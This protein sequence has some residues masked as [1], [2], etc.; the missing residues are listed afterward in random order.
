MATTIQ[1]YAKSKKVRIHQA[2]AVIKAVLGE[3]PDNL[4]DEDI[5]R[6]ELANQAPSLPPSQD[7]KALPQSEPKPENTVTVSEQPE[8]PQPQPEEPQPQSQPVDQM[9]TAIQT[10]Q[11]Q[12]TSQPALSGS[13]LEAIKVIR[14]TFGE[15]G[16]QV[17]LQKKKQE[18]IVT[19]ATGDAVRQHDERKLY[20]DVRLRVQNELQLRDLIEDQQAFDYQMTQH[21]QL[22]TQRKEDNNKRDKA[23]DS[24]LSEL[25]A[26]QQETNFTLEALGLSLI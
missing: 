8:E 23:L 3:V 21:N 25:L 5:E 1:E 22:M 13:D 16:V 7:Q 9:T 20:E 6:I 17:F 14:E 4:T 10:V 26:K 15:Q 11:P 24:Q 19:R 2:K 12:T 18:Q